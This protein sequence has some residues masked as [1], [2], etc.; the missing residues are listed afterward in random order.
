MK[1]VACAADLEGWRVLI[2][3]DSG[4]I[5]MHVVPHRRQQQGLAMLGAEYEMNIELGEGLR[6][7]ETPI[8]PLQ[9]L[10][11]ET[12]MPLDP[13]RGPGLS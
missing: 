7:D 1:V 8:S 9:G 10:G 11:L 3:E 6:H 13:G 4:Q 12:V 2:I 5:G